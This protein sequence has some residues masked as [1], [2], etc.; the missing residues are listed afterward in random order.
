MTLIIVLFVRRTTRE[1]RAL[2]RE[3][4]GHTGLHRS[5]ALSLGIR[6]VVIR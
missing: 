5:H 6:R 4:D 3:L 1:D 2:Q